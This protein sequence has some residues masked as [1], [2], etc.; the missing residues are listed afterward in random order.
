MIRVFVVVV[1][2]LFVLCFFWLVFVGDCEVKKKRLIVN[3]YYI[4]TTIV[5][6]INSIVIFILNIIANY[7]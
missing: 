5:T 1:A 4:N 3:G 7:L 2:F 6:I